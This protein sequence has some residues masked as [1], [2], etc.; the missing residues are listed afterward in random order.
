MCAIPGT[1]SNSLICWKAISHSPRATTAP[2]RSPPPTKR[3]L[4]NTRSA[5][6]KRWHSSLVKYSPLTLAEYAIDFASSKAR[7][8]PSTVLMSGFGAPARTAMPMDERATDLW[9]SARTRP[10][11]RNCRNR[12]SATMTMSAISPRFSR[13]WIEV[14]PVPTDVV[15]VTIFFFVSRSSCG[16]S[17]RCAAVNAP[18][19]ITMK[20][21]PGSTIVVIASMVL[22]HQR[23]GWRMRALDEL[24]KIAV[25][26]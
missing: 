10:S 23:G 21:F 8:S 24:E 25:E 11:S 7:L 4:G 16:T 22:S 20:S 1:G 26:L 17:A 13:L 6:P 15:A 3:L 5:I 18:E 12:P 19:V 9:P 14:S 2:V